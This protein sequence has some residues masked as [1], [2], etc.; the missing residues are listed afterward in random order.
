MWSFSIVMASDLAELC[1]PSIRTHP[2]IQA[3]LHYN[4]CKCSHQNQ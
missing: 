4:L 2:R 3:A 1:I